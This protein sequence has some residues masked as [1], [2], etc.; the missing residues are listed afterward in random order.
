MDTGD[1]SERFDY[2]TFLEQ[3]P[4]RPGVYDM[5]D[6]QGVTLYIGKAKNLKNRLSS[7]FRPTGLTT[8]TMA[9][10]SKIHS[11]NLTITR[12]E[13]EALILEQNLIKDRRPQYNI[14]LKDD[15]SYPYIYLSTDDEYPSVV[16]QRGKPKNKKGQFFGPF[17]SGWAVRESLNLMQKVFKVRQCD[18]NYFRN[19]T[20]PCLQYQIDR[21]KGP[22]VGLVDPEEYARDVADTRQ[23]LEGKSQQLIRTLIER[24]EAES[25]QLQFEQAA[26]IRDQINHLRQVQESQSADKGV[27]DADVIGLSERS[28]SVCFDVLFVRGGRVLGHKSYF[29]VFK[30]DADRADYLADFLGQFY[31]K[32]SDSRNYP[33]EIILPDAYPESDILEA[34]IS[35]VSGK[36]VV[37]KHR[38]RGGRSDWLALANKN[39]DMSLESQLSSKVNSLGRTESLSDLLA[40]PEGITRMECFDISH[41]FG[42]ETVASCVVF[43]REGPEKSEYRRFNVTGIEPGDD[44]G[45]MRFALHKRYKHLQ[46]HPEKSPSLIIIDGGKGQLGIAEEV[47]GELSL[48]HIPLLGVAKGITRKPGLETLLFDGDELE[49]KGH[50]AALLLI[51]QIRDEAHRFAITG[52]RQRR[53]KAR[54]VSPLESIPGVGAKRRSALLKFFGGR[55]GVMDAP[56]DEL[57][58]V[59]GI[60]RKLAEQIYDHLHAR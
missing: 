38:V 33:S 13:T 19:R 20:R 30:V 14:L 16:Y 48:Q 47:M 2:K 15:K 31:I 43:G 58:K 21:C 18:N 40:L 3:A 22:C 17:P 45:A 41:T 8:K 4:N 53:G 24:M 1:H 42:E 27:A 52:H 51:Q 25:A 39:A 6:E 29:P 46:D 57:A 26:E 36:K 7:Y 34:A 23:F 9:L 59:E 55:H 54:Q 60:S 12:S 35:E 44:Y 10:V 49:P 37:I 28:G 11:I 32:L 50:E 5:R 56:V